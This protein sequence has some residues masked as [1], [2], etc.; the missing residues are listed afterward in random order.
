[1]KAGKDMKSSEG[2]P[3]PVRRGARQQQVIER[4]PQIKER[5]ATLKPELV[6]CS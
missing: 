6:G 2:I 5:N 3:V 1:M 4:A